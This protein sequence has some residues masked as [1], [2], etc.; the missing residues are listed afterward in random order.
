VSRAVLHFR[1]Q[2][3]FMLSIFFS[4]QMNFFYCIQRHKHLS[5]II[6]LNRS[7]I[8]EFI[9]NQLLLLP[10]STRVFESFGC[11]FIKVWYFLL[12]HSLH[13]N[14]FP[15]LTTEI[16]HEKYLKVIS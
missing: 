8:N 1:W 15:F 12:C 14:T 5:F 4:N 11:I 6:R 10:E 2:E 9:R 16:Y 7:I 3:L 13:Q